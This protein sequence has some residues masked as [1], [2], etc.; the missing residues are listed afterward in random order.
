ML[1]KATI[2][3][4]NINQAVFKIQALIFSMILFSFQLNL[5]TLED[6]IL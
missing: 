6:G 4:A 2:H 5:S 3:Y 1:P